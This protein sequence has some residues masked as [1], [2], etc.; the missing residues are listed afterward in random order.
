MVALAQKFDTGFKGL[1]TAICATLLI[2]MVF[3]TVWTVVM[4][5]IFLDAPFWSDTLTMFFNVW[6]VFLALAITVRD[7][8]HISMTMLYEIL[9]PIVG[10]SCEFLWTVLI[11]LFGIFIA[12]WGFDAS[13][14]VPGLYWEFGYMSK[15][16]PMMIMPTVGVL[17]FV[18]A[19]IV[20]FEDILRA[21]RGDLT[22]HAHEIEDIK[23]YQRMAQVE[24]DEVEVVERA[25]AH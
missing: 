20:I 6:T 19:A 15:K 22:V 23:E 12:I 14:N 25:D 1:L 17:M 8:T 10:F 13:W 21:K 2:L 5:Y 4:R 16:W 9:P 24:A 3:F 18:M 11:C 7:R